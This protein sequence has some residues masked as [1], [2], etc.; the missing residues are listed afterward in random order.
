MGYNVG[1]RVLAN[2]RHLLVETGSND[3]FPAK[4]IRVSD[5]HTV[6]GSGLMARVCIAEYTVED[7]DDEIVWT[8]PNYPA[9]LVEYLTR[10]GFQQMWLSESVIVPVPVEE[11]DK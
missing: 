8:V 11:S 9:Y 7:L 10:D 4:I 1:D 2:P 5:W 3:L 6:I